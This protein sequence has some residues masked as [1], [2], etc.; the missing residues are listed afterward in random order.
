MSHDVDVVDAAKF[1]QAQTSTNQDPHCTE[2]WIAGSGCSHGSNQ[3]YQGAVFC[4]ALGVV[5]NGMH[6]RIIG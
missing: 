5:S 1:S 2:H 3:V 4:I 6:T